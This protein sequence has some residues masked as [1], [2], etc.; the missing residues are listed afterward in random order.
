MPEVSTLVTRICGQ[1]S[2]TASFQADSSLATVR[3]PVI[4]RLNVAA[5]E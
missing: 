5:G 1:A 3:S 4:L 2:R